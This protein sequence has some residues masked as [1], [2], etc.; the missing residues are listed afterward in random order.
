MHT[1]KTFE[2]ILVA[3][4]F[5]VSLEG[6]SAMTQLYLILQCL[7]QGEPSP[8]CFPNAG[9]DKQVDM[10]NWSTNLLK[11]YRNVLVEKKWSSI[12]CLYVPFQFSAQLIL[13]SYN[14]MFTTHNEVREIR[15]IIEVGN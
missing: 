14:H 3:R 4:A 11:N 6:V 1:P 2:V 13:G 12:W 5:R 10:V 15:N 9:L 8:F 7:I